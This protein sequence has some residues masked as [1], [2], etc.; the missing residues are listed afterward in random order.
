MKGTLAQ[1]T[2]AALG[3]I[4]SFLK[5]RVLAAAEAWCWQARLVWDTF[6]QIYVLMRCAVQFSFLIIAPQ[7]CATNCPFKLTPGL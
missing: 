3:S 5:Q 1:L 6:W 4:P 2:A 7:N